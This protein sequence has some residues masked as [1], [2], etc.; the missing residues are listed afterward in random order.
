MQSIWNLGRDPLAVHEQEGASRRCIC[1][2]DLRRD[3]LPHPKVLEWRCADTI[4]ACPG[5][6]GIQRTAGEDALI[7]LIPPT[8][9]GADAVPEPT[10]TPLPRPGVVPDNPGRNPWNS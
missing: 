9:P 2:E 1:H 4:Q 3:L 10:D 5:N 6:R 7:A 8:R